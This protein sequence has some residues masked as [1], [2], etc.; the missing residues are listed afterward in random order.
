MRPAL[1][2]WLEIYEAIH[3]ERLCTVQESAA[4]RR[5]L[6]SQPADLRGIWSGPVSDP[7]LSVVTKHPSGTPAAAVGVSMTAQRQMALLSAQTY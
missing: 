2:G 3:F 5:F 7:C 6:D 4:V 1:T